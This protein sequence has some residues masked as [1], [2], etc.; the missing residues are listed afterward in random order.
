MAP[1]FENGSNPFLVIDTDRTDKV[2]T[3]ANGVGNGT[4]A[5]P[6]QWEETLSAGTHTIK[7]QW[8]SDAGSSEQKG[9]T[10][11]ARVLRVE[12]K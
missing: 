11:G 9:A 1:F 8:K 7:I 6:I 2:H 4:D 5:M 3:T 10:D 12:E